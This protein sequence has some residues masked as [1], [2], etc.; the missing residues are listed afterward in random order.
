[1][2]VS[3]EL[4]WTRR[5]CAGAA[6]ACAINIAHNRPA[7]T[8]ISTMPGYAEPRLR[9]A[10][11]ACRRRP[12]PG[13]R[14]AR[15]ADPP[16]DLVRVRVERA[17]RLALQHGALGPRLQ[18]DLE[19]DQRRARGAR[20]RARRRQ[21]RDRDRER[22]GGAAPGDRDDRRRRL[23]HRRLER[24]LRRLAQPAALHAVALRHRDD[25][26]RSRATSTPG[27]RRSGPRP[28]CCSARRSATRASTSS[29]SRRSP[30]SP[31]ST[32]C[33]CWSTRPSRRPG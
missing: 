29:T 10:G 19:P 30:R 7:Q 21:R 4:R 12:R 15:G 14:R 20:R 1:M 2:V 13:D 24:A 31:T 11:A 28:S 6:E 26:R 9:H 23:A 8:R 18:P 5:S 32:T 17:R 25:L 3:A 16:D 33:R 27:A 22:P